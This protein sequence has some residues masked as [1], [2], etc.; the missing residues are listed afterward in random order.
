MT[1]DQSPFPELAK[2]LRESVHAALPWLRA[3]SAAHAIRPPAPGKWS[4]AQVVGHLIDS[5]TNNHQRFVRA[6]ES[7]TL[8][9]PP[10]EQDHWV[11]VQNYEA[12]PWDE[13]VTFWHVY[14][15]HL[16]HVVERIP[17]DRRAIPITI[18]TSAPVSL[19]FL[20]HDYTVHMNRHLEHL[21]RG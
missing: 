16:A 8:T 15:Q 5:A 11:A 12:R 17:E 20:V 1:S 14:N 13:L 19:G 6:Q 10:Y 3:I 4:P 7:Q 21:R 2:E 18:G 9:F